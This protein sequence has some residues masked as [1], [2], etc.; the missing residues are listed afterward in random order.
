[1]IIDPTLE[2]PSDVKVLDGRGK[3]VLPGFV[4]THH[5]MFQI[6]TRDLDANLDSN[7]LFDWLYKMYRIGNNVRFNSQKLTIT[8]A[9]YQI[10]SYCRVVNKR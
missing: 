1:M 4:N 9:G 2:A 3:L 10:I 5:H 7:S 6:F 8:N